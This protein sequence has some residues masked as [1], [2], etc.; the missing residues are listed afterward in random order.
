[1]HTRTKVFSAAAMIAALA[2]GG[3]AFTD[4]NTMPTSQNVG[5]GTVTVSGATVDHIDYNINAND[6]SKLDGVTVW[7][8]GDYTGSTTTVQWNNV[9]TGSPLYAPV[10]CTTGA[11]DTTDTKFTCVAPINVVD[12]TSLDVT[13]TT[14]P[15]S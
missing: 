12:A 15:K 4:S 6:V 2:A 9:N 7:L 10:T 8:T 13:V 3:S 1:M 11:F 14:T 5:Y